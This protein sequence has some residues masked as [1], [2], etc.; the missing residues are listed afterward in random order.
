M[1]SVAVCVDRRLIY[2]L[3]GSKLLLF[4]VSVHSVG[5][6]V[7]FSQPLQS[8]LHTNPAMA[9]ATSGPRFTLA[10][11]NQ[12]AGLGQAYLTFY[13]AADG[14]A[15]SL[16]S[17]WGL[18]VLSDRQGH[19]LFVRNSLAGIYAYR[20]AVSQ[21]AALQIAVQASAEQRSI[22]TAQ[23][24]FAENINPLDG[25]VQ[26]HGSVD[27]PDNDYRLFAD[28]GSGLLLFTSQFFAGFALQH[29]NTPNESFYSNTTVPLP[30]RWSSQLG[31]RLAS[32][33][34][35][36]TRVTF[37]PYLVYSAQ[38][39]FHMLQTCASMGIGSL[40]GGLAYRHSLRNPDAIV[41]MAG[42]RHSILSIVYS[43][44]ATVSPLKGAG[45]GSHELTLSINL[46][47]SEKLR[48]QRNRRLQTRCPGLF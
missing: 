6:D 43:F 5:Q 28:F 35:F 24:V 19:G 33:Q 14:F 17:S 44:D 38:G 39:G 36:Q 7:E 1:R 23:L 40:V 21:K 46:S 30:L 2:P 47:D 8:S 37:V 9:G 4:F 29:V 20:L 32:K 31:F 45:G 18:F 12:W 15:E 3:L 25:S 34:A 41:M 11:R 26:T 42:L 13:A 16:S 22:N 48:A 27:L 10:Y